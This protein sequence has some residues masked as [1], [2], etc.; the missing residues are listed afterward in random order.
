MN[1]TRKAVGMTPKL[2]PF[3]CSE[4]TITQVCSTR[5]VLKGWGGGSG[6]DARPAWGA[7]SNS[8]ASAR[9]VNQGNFEMRRRSWATA[10]DSFHARASIQLDRTG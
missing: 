6:S 9:H 4:T 8:K 7:S 1:T 5:C 10:E 2:I 3:A